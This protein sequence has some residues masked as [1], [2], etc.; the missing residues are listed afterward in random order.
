MHYFFIKVQILKKNI[1][2]KLLEILTQRKG[3]PPLHYL[4]NIIKSSGVGSKDFGVIKGGAK[5]GI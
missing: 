1:F 3:F 5:G 4:A 2:M